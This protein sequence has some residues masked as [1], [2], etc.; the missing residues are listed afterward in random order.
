MKNRFDVRAALAI[1]FALTSG[2]VMSDQSKAGHHQ[3]HE[4]KVAPN[5]QKASLNNLEQA[6]QHAQ[7][8]LEQTKIAGLSI[9]EIKSLGLVYIVDL[10]E[11]DAASV[12]SNHLILRKEDGFSALVYPAHSS[13]ELSTE[14]QFGMDGLTG[15]SGM[16]GMSG[17]NQRKGNHAVKTDA[18]ARRGIEAW[19]WMNSLQDDFLLEDITSMHGLYLVDLYDKKTKKLANQAF[20]RAVDGYIALVRPLSMKELRFPGVA[21]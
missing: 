7:Q 9:G 17:A 8:W 11:N 2:G 19:L 16:T 6:R 5:L 18:D 20:V 12:H 14:Q 21:K 10:I 3:H 1:L 4:A 15:M 13:Q